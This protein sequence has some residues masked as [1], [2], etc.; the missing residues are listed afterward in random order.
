LF[1]FS[2]KSAAI[3]KTVRK[4]YEELFLPAESK[5]RAK[6]ITDCRQAFEGI[7]SAYGILSA[8]K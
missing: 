5:W 4:E 2:A 8:V 3:R 6:A 7:F 1:Q